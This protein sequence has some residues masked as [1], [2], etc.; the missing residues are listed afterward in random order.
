MTCY[1]CHSSWNR[2]ASAAT[3][4]M[5]ANAQD[6]DAA[7]RRRRRRATTRRTTSRS[8]ATTSSCSGLD[9]TSTGNRIAPVRS[10]CAVLVS[11]QNAN[12]EWIYSQQQTIS[13]EGYQRPGLQHLLPHTVR[14]TRDQDV[15]RLPRLARRATTT[16]GWRSSCCR[17]PTSSTS[18]AATSGSATGKRRLRGR[19]RHRARRAAGGHRQRPAQ[20][21]VPRRLRDARD[22]TAASCTQ[23]RCITAAT[24]RARPAAA[25]RVP[26]RRLRQ[27][28]LPRLRHRQHRQQG[29]L[30]SGSS[31]RRCRRSASGST[32]RRSTRRRSPRRPRSASTRRAS[33]YPENEEQPI[34]LLYGYLYV[35]DREEGLIVVGNRSKANS[36][37]DAA[38]RQPAQ[39]LP[40]SARRRST[41]TAS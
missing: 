22:G 16:P 10:S 18:W 17:A 36:G 20:A 39:Q 2:A 1:A 4:R 15:H 19:R 35:A 41:R 8:C 9:G 34:H 7:Q 11:S 23:R 33:A 25:R 24:R 37:V 26:L 29:L 12:R 5:K 38:R 31:P 6:A 40:R 30:A 21:R 28:R 14:A 3:C 13:A 32:S 27:G